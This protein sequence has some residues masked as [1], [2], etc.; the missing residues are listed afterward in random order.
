MVAYSFK[1]RFVDPIRVGLSRVSLSFDCLPKRQTIRAHRKR[2][3]RP[4]EDLQL[5][6]GMRTRQCFLIGRARCVSVHAVTITVGK[7]T[8]PTSLDGAHIGGGHLHDFAQADGF[9]SAED[10]LAFWQA[11]HGIGKFEGVLIRW[12]PL[13]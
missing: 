4:G 12:E 13:T 1:E 2:H 5:Y 7:H 9:A 10:M 3:A 11:E 6:R 8:M